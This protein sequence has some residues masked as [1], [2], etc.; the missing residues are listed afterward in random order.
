MKLHQYA[1]ARAAN[2]CLL[3]AAMLVGACNASISGDQ[4]G[5]RDLSPTGGTAGTTVGGAAGAPVSA[6][7]P[8]VVAATDCKVDAAP[9]AGVG[10]WRRLTAVQYRNTVADL[11]GLQADSSAFLQDSK[12][13]AFATNAELPPQSGDIDSYQATAEKLAATAVGNLSG[14]LSG[15]DRV[16][17]G[18]DACAASFI[19]D[20]GSRAYR[21]ALTDKQKTAL[22]AVY[23]V[24]KQ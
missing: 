1:P 24:G 16:A 14:L 11:L 23:Q 4:A 12:T 8:A 18:D 6:G 10:R 21:H 22:L 3:A 19:D 17:A 9:D 2:G 7:A 5:A 20:F 13:G 15:C